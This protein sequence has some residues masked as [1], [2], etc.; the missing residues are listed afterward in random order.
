M[1]LTPDEIRGT[2][3]ALRFYASVRRACGRPVDKEADVARQKFEEALAVEASPPEVDALG[4][5][6]AGRREFVLRLVDNPAPFGGERFPTP[7]DR[8]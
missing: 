2:V 5:R 4:L 1:T 7:K 8:K 6:A 3:F